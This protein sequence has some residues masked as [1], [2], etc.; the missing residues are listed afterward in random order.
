MGGTLCFDDRNRVFS[1]SKQ[2]VSTIE[3]LSD[4]VFSGG[5]RHH[6]LVKGL[7][8]EDARWIDI[9]VPLSDVF[10][11]YAQTEQPIVVFASGDPLFFGFANTIRREIPDAEIT[12]FP[13]FNSLQMLAHRLVMPYHDMTIVSLTGRP[14]H[15]F[16]RALIERKPKIGVL[17]DGEHTPAAI[18]SRMLEY[19]YGYYEMSVGEHLGSETEE[20]VTTLSLEEASK[21]DFKRPNCLILTPPQSPPGGTSQ[22]GSIQKPPTGERFGGDFPLGI[23]DADFA[24]LDGRA[25]M[26]T[27]API[28]LLTLAALELQNRHSFWD[29]GFCTGSVSIEA[30]LQFPHLHVT[31]FEVREEGRRLMDINSH[32]FKTP[33]IASKIGDFIE[34]STEDC[35]PPDAIF[36][37]GH[38]G[39]LKEIVTKAEQ[40]L[41]P[42]GVM[43]YNCVAPESV[44]DERIRQDSRQVFEQTARQLGLH[45]E[46]PMRVAINDFHPIII[47]KARKL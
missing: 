12:V 20:R 33:G 39:R 32:R 36:I 7:I 23:P 2:S 42:G 43:V 10:A 14:W 1:S 8:P 34:V 13:Y 18:A 27:K 6:E 19:G 17:T 4:C 3:T 11:Q 45:L 38:G 21:Q 46:E 29:I 30:K 40:A 28:R 15:E 37:G 24:L 25:K 47:L 16:D 26:I 31:A 41:L 9:T 5:K 22:Q 35:L 44:A